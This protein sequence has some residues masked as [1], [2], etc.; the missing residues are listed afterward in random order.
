MAQFP[1]Y[2]AGDDITVVADVQLN[3]VDQPLTGA[4][5]RAALVKPGR[6]ELAPGTAVVTCTVDGTQTN[7]I[8]ASFPRAQT[9]LLTAGPY[10]IEVQIEAGGKRPMFARRSTLRSTPPNSTASCLRIPASPSMCAR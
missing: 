7:R 10:E 3:G 5:V 2:T 6:S 8:T 4:T 1:R 9:G